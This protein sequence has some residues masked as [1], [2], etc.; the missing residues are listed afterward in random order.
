MV[1][2]GSLTLAPFILIMLILSATVYLL[3]FLFVGLY[4]SNPSLTAVLPCLSCFSA[5]SYNSLPEGESLRDETS[6]IASSLI[7]EA[8]QVTGD[9]GTEVERARGR[10]P[11]RSR[12][13]ESRRAAAHL[14]QRD[15]SRRSAM[16]R[17]EETQ[18]NYTS[19]LDCIVQANYWVVVLLAVS[20]Q[21]GYLF[22]SSNLEEEL[23]SLRKHPSMYGFF[24]PLLL[25]F[26]G[27]GRLLMGVFLDSSAAITYQPKVQAM[28]PF[29]W[30]Y[31]PMLLNMGGS[32]FFA[33]TSSAQFY[34]MGIAILSFSY[35]SLI[36]LSHFILCRN[37]GIKLHTLSSGLFGVW[38]V[39]CQ[40]LLTDIISRKIGQGVSSP[41]T[42]SN[43]L[44]CLDPKC[45]QA[46]FI[47]SA[48]LSFISLLLFSLFLLRRY[49]FVSTLNSLSF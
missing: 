11:V 8:S 6:N 19:V 3:A 33:F 37:F 30:Y 4:S 20:N 16:T 18:V 14:R 7:A 12:A 44:Y 17:R 24:H 26:D 5:F 47:V 13:A 15:A 39:L 2:G 45:L 49:L 28:L 43:G 9:D 23:F 31:L 29:A 22:L 32:I 36:T 10:E 40:M 35:G 25:L 48:C 27:L 46:G 34:S 21:S 1:E 41:D 38:S 42:T